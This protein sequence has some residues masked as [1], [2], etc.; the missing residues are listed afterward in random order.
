MCVR[1]DDA[2]GGGDYDT[3]RPRAAGRYH[4][5]H[6]GLRGRHSGGPIGGGD[7][8]GHTNRAGQCR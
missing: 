4:G 5:D 2:S 7:V 3:G 1:Y 8:R 6:G